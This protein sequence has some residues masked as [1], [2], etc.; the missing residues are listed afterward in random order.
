MKK[1][2][3]LPNT[4]SAL[5][6]LGLKDLAV[7][8][9][10]PRYKISMSDA[11]HVPKR[12]RFDLEC[13]QVCAVCFAGAVIAIS[14]G[15]KPNQDVSL[16]RLS[17]KA[18]DRLSALDSVRKG[19]FVEAMKWFRGKWVKDPY[20]STDEMLADLPIEIERRLEKVEAAIG[21][22][23]HYTHAC[24]GTWRKKMERAANILA[25]YRL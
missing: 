9:A 14:F 1:N 11:W 20:D 7:V 13:D 16:H 18:S 2:V 12:N 25:K 19:D 10:D 21:E 8:E 24:R 23:P 5:I 22:I 17:P 6:R 4:L 3:K 15:A